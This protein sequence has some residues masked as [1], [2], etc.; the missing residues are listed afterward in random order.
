MALRPCLSAGLPFT[1][2]AQLRRFEQAI[3]R[4]IYVYVR[5]YKTSPKPGFLLR[6]MSPL[7]VVSGHSLYK[8]NPAQGRANFLSHGPAVAIRPH[9]FDSFYLLQAPIRGKAFVRR[10]RE[11][12][13][14]KP[15][16]ATLTAPGHL[17]KNRSF[18]YDFSCHTAAIRL[19][20]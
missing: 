8:K 3:Y 19:F 9:T 6:C 7:W 14:V 20:S 17:H 1:N 13:T 4:R 15:G 5:A 12:V 10:G 16:Q 2:P 18:Q 11:E